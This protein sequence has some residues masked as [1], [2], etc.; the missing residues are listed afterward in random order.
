M[1]NSA[2]AIAEV[3]IWNNG[4][5]SWKALSSLLEHPSAFCSA[6]G[7]ITADLKASGAAPPQ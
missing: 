2:K 4:R 5:N 1:T 6:G 3:A 7:E